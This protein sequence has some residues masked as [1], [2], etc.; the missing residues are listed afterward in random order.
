MLNLW[1]KHCALIASTCIVKRRTADAIWYLEY[2]DGR[3]C[4]FCELSN[5]ELYT[6]DT[7]EEFELITEIA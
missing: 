7:Q 4:G 6:C 1:E 3:W 5:G 2:E